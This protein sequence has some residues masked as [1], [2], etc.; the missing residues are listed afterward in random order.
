VV[1]RVVSKQIIDHP[2]LNGLT[3]KFQ[4]AYRRHHS[5]ETAPPRV[6][7]DIIGSLDNQHVTL[8]GLLDISA[9]FDCVDHEILPSRLKK[10]L[11]IHGT[12]LEWIT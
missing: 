5:T 3:P 1:E 8:L 10:T 11:G 7:S 2:Q 6:M 12:E 9:A 4:S